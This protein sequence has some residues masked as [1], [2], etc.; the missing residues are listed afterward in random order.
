MQTETIPLDETHCFTKEFVD[1]ISGNQNLKSFYSKTPSIENFKEIIECRRFSK[2]KRTSL[3]E[4]LSKQYAEIAVHPNVTDNISSLSQDKT[5][6][7]TTGH[8]LNI[9]TGPLYFIYK[10]I[11]VINTCKVLKKAYPDCHFVPVYWMASEDHDFEEISYFHLD[12]KKI[13]WETDQEGAVGRFDPK[14]LASIAAT[15]PDGASFFEEAYKQNTLANA[16]RHYVNHLFQDEGLV[17]VDADDPTLKRQLIPVIEDDLFHHSAEK[18]VEETS[19]KL[20]QIG[21]KTQVHARQINFFYI[22][23]NTR[24]RIE[25]TAKDYSVVNTELKFS[26]EEIR[27]L[28]NDHPE[29]FSPNVILRPL[30]EEIILPNLAYVGGPSELVYWLQLKSVF[31]HFET[32]FPIL[33]PRNFALVYSKNNQEKWA[34]TGL[35]TTDLFLDS[36]A[37]STKWVSLNSSKDLTF[38]D[39]IKSLKT[40]ENEALA[41]AKAVDPTLA[42][43]IEALHTTFKNKIEKAEKKLLRAEKRKYEDKTH[44][45]EAVK[46]ALFPGGTLQERKINFLNFY[47]K[48]PLFIEKLKESFDPFR[49]EMYL[50]L[51]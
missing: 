7:I 2:E 3:V 28:I 35:Q 32:P 39:Q 20:E 27:M 4:A 13:P 37:A 49:F 46:E 21:F 45:I 24:E 34:K 5:F 14:E 50:L 44:Q 51:D 19:N 22:E 33:L 23:D 8:Q 9:F 29:Q 15:L 30:Y 41:K 42:Q 6:T 17:V 26:E 12:G 16:V 1:Y 40:L 43:H 10:I 25:K 18:L 31:D 11:T 36:E 48:D 38:S 47:L